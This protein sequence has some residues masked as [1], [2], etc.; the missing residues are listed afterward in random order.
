MSTKV[1]VLSNVFINVTANKLKLADIFFDDKIVN[2]IPKTQISVSWDE[3]STKEKLNAFVNKLHLVKLPPSSTVINGEFLLAI[4]GGI[5]PHVHFSTPGYENHEDFEHG[6]TAAAYG[7]TTTVIDM[8]CTSYP[9][10]TSLENFRLK[11]LSIQPRSLVDFAF[12]GG[13]SGNDFIDDKNIQRQ[14]DGLSK[15]GVAGFK[16]YLISGMDTFGDLN[17][18]QLQ[19]VADLVSQSKKIFAV[20][21]EDKELI[22]TRTLLI[23]KQGRYDWRS[24]CEAR[25]DKAEMQAIKNVFDVAK[26]TKCK[27]LIVHISSQL[28]LNLVRNAKKDGLDFSAETCP[29]Y[30]YFT[31]KDFDIPSISNFLKT[32]PP[33]KKEQDREALWEGLKDGIISF[34]STD[35]AGCN[36]NTEKT[37]DNFWE[38]YSGIPGVEH[39]IPFLFSEAFHKRKFTIEQTIRLLSSN[40]ADYFGLKKR[41]KLEVGYNADIALINLW[42]EETIKSDNMHSKGRYTPFEGVTFKAIVEKAL[43][44]GKIIAD[45]KSPPEAVV[46]HGEF[47]TIF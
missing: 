14:I 23:Q 31:Q 5:D 36:P 17:K 26:R 39:R 33:V 47:I 45:R 37:S 29:H 42:D 24:Y 25:D 41:G 30:L 13:V 20:H 9:P 2:I 11:L 1:R 22:N 28:G 8:P 44:R 16:V 27:T 4:P 6:S 38:V 12:W 3:I 46:G 10:V 7:G 35:H 43:L 32:D 21:S 34:V 40:A 15:A 18:L 19:V